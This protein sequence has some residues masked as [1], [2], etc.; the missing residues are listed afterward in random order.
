MRKTRQPRTV[1]ARSRPAGAA[2]PPTR[3]PWAFCIYVTDD[4]PVSRNAVQNL[5]DLCEAHVPGRYTI[6]VVDLLQAPG[7]A[8]ADKI[9]AIPTVVRTAPKPARTVIGDLSDI[10]R[11]T[12]G[13]LRPDAP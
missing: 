4:R 3:Q 8:R 13:L 6:E 1:A 9:G 12:E 5:T 10:T 2:A 7:R 11:A